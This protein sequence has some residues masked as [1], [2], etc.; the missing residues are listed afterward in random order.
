MENT[1]KP[2]PTDAR[3][4]AAI[5]LVASKIQNCKNNICIFDMIDYVKATDVVEMLLE[6]AQSRPATLDKAKVSDEII[7]NKAIEYASQYDNS[8]DIK[9]IEDL[10]EA[11]A[12]DYFE[13]FKACQSLSE[14]P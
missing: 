5:K 2:I 6:F 9:T 10:R 1:N 7:R 11:A 13:G 8:S 4:A 14:Q 12:T 3:K